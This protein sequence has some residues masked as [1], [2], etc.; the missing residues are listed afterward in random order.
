[1][2]ENYQLAG[3]HH[4]S[5]PRNFIGLFGH[6]NAIYFKFLSAIKLFQVWPPGV[7][8]HHIA[9]PGPPKCFRGVRRSF[10]HKNSGGNHQHGLG[11]DSGANPR[12]DRQL[13]QD[14]NKLPASFPL[15]N[16]AVIKE[17]FL[18]APIILVNAALTLQQLWNEQNVRLSDEEETF[19]T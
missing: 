15:A 14:W 6:S 16:A 4:Y 11:G 7:P 17:R 18:D 13:K 2:I 8:S 12:D 3:E 1:M 9:L 19:D 5:E 10:C